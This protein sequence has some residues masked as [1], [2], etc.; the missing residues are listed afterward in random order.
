MLSEAEYKQFVG[1]MKALKAKA[2][3]VGQ[4]LQSIANLFSGPERLPL[5]VR[6]EFLSV[7]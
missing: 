6:F 4:V 1:F 2:L 3:K 5:L 7:L